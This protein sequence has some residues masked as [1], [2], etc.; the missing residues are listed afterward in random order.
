MTI[1]RP[2]AAIRF[3]ALGL[4]RR[5]GM[6]LLAEVLDDAG[7][8]KGLRPL[9]GTVEF[10]ETAAE[11]LI[12]EFREE[13]GVTVAPLGPPVFM[14]NIYL[15]E[16]AQGHEVLAIFEAACAEGALPGGMR[17][18]FHEDDGSPCFARW[19]AL[20]ALDTPEGP[21]LFPSGLKTVL[22]ER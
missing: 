12:R 21:A 8:R 9:G 15:H 20:D 1:W 11:A 16:G 7:R 3:K 22:E 10:G 18:A 19:V 5:D 2:A 4:L 17:F 14:E 13:L 6:L